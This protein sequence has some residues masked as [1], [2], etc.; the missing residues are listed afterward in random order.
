MYGLHAGTKKLGRCGEV[1]VNGGS[2]VAFSQIARKVIFI[3]HLKI[4]GTDSYR[5]RDSF[6]WVK[7]SEHWIYV[8]TPLLP[9]GKKLVDNVIK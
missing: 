8:R 5:T 2:T 9:F 3:S 1:A 7:K 6:T 4:G